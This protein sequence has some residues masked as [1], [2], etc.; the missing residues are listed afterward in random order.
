M[1]PE[2]RRHLLS[3]EKQ[4]G[5]VLRRQADISTRREN[6]DRT[7]KHEDFAPEVAGIASLFRLMA[8]AIPYI[9]SRAGQIDRS[10]LETSR[11][12]IT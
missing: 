9:L 10:V 12:G 8:S 11:E 7:F 5:W 6:F 4:N 1:T 2:L 3:L